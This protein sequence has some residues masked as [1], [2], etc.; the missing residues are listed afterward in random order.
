MIATGEIGRGGRAAPGAVVAFGIALVLPVGVIDT[1][2]AIPRRITA[3]QEEAGR[4]AFV[5]VVEER[6]VIAA[7]NAIA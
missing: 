3:V 5:E 1:E 4:A 2:G 6:L 7:T